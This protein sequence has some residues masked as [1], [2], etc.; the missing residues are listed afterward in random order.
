[1]SADQGIGRR[2]QADVLNDQISKA[3]ALQAL[4]DRLQADFLAANERGDMVN[5]ALYRLAMKL[6]KA[7]L[8]DTDRWIRL[9]M[10]EAA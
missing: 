8:E 9:Q 5:Q 7:E 4:L 3:S 2:P 1:M 10:T 6:T